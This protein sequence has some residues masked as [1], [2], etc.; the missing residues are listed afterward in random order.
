MAAD[1]A[2]RSNSS[3]RQNEEPSAL[4][5]A[6]FVDKGGVGKTTAVAHIGVALAERGLDVLLVDLA[7][8]QG[9]LAKQFGMWET[10]REGR[11]WPNITTTFQAEWSEI[12]DQV[13]TAAQELIAAT[14]EGPDLL[15]R[16][17]RST[18]STRSSPPMTTPPTGIRASTAF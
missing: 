8:K 6:S 15:R 13:P 2:L 1:D 17:N 5:L 4:R 10:V 7:G 3:P 11:D 18:A 12:A 9:D 14:G 16:T